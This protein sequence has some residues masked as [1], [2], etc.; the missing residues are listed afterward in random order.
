M[1][2]VPTIRLIPRTPRVTETHTLAI[3]GVILIVTVGRN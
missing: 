3:A 1:I 2:T